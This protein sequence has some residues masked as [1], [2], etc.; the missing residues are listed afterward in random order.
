MNSEEICPFSVYQDSSVD[1]FGSSEQSHSSLFM[2]LVLSV[3]VYQLLKIKVF[4]L[5]FLFAA[6]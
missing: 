3:H 5:D 1:F 6:P 2:D 4:V